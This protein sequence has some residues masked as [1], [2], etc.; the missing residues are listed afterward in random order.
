VLRGIC[1]VRVLEELPDLAELP[2]ILSALRPDRILL[3]TEA[4]SRALALAAELERLAGPEVIAVG[5]ISDP[6]LLTEL[7]QHGVTRFLGSPFPA[8]LVRSWLQP[9]VPTLQYVHGDTGRHR[10]HVDG[11]VVRS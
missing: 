3:G 1:S 6:D 10:R 11:P 8:E 4:P 2:R 7:A 5:R 9:D